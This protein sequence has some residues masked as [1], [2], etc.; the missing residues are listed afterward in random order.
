MGFPKGVDRFDGVDPF[1]RRIP[2]DVDVP[3]DAAGRDLGR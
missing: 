2:R 3:R 1:C